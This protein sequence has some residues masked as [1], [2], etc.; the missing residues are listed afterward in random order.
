MAND[1][2]TGNLRRLSDADLAVAEDEPDVR[3]WT[4]VSSDNR[5]LGEVE[6][7]IVDTAAMKVRF[8]E[9]DPEDEANGSENETVYVPIES[10][11]LD[12]QGKRVLLRAADAGMWRTLVPAEF[13]AQFGARRGT[14]AES[15]GETTGAGEIN[16][17]T[18]AEEEVRVGKR[19]VPAGEVRVGKHVET[20][21]V[22]ENVSVMLEQVHIERRPVSDTRSAEIRASEGELRV[23]IVEEEVIVEKR[24]VVK[25][26]LIVS[27]EQ[28]QE[29]RPVDVEIR[30]EEFDVHDEGKSARGIANRASER[31]DMDRR[32]DR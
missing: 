25:E 31:D 5:E 14:T 16:R 2:T 6:D 15:R 10:V 3:G 21:H 22:R 11:D 7:L 13:A 20:E 27:K 17:M 26:E 12:R 9:I 8:L 4:L 19:T 28:V 24:P 1:F 23:P 29:T 18:R 32:G 30:K